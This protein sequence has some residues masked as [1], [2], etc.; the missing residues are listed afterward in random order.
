MDPATADPNI[1][2]ATIMNDASV[3]TDVGVVAAKTLQPYFHGPPLTEKQVERAED[4]LASQDQGADGSVLEKRQK[5][6]DFVLSVLSKAGTDAS[7]TSDTSAD[8]AP[9]VGI[10]QPR[11]P[12][13]IDVEPI[14]AGEEFR[15]G[16]RPLDTTI[17]D[18]TPNGTPPTDE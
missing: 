16:Q 14:P 6:Y 2:L 11:P 10:N 5:A 13:E 17:I 8:P 15:P 9:T 1:A 7:D 4:Y 3:P 18:A 12:E